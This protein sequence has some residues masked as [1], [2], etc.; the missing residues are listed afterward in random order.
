MTKFEKAMKL[1][2]ER[3][4]NDKEEIIALATISLPAGEEVKPRPAVRMVSSYYEDGVFYVSTDAR[5]NKMLQIAQNNEVGVC[6]FGWY[7]FQGITENLGW[8]KDEKNARIREKFKKVFEWFDQDGDEDN[9]NSIV[10]KI[11]LTEGVIIDFEK[12]YGE[13]KYEVDFFHKTAE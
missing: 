3:C 11:T 6:G 2:E 4:G 5:K 7:S 1:I 13:L 12:K 8:V 9:P 10:L